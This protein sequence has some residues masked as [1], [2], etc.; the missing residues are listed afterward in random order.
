[1]PPLLH[2]TQSL[3]WDLLLPKARHATK[4]IYNIP[5][6]LNSPTPSSFSAK[7]VTSSVGCA[8]M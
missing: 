7:Q 1:M 4:T 3:C 8:R 6:P 2:P 5:F